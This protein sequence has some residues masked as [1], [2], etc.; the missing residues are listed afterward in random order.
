VADDN[1]QALLLAA[2]LRLSPGTKRTPVIGR[3]LAGQCGR[4]SECD[5]AGECALAGERGLASECGRRA[6]GGWGTERSRVERREHD[7]QDDRSTTGPAPP[8]QYRPEVPAAKSMPL[9]LMPA[10]ERSPDVVFTSLR[11]RRECVWV[12]H[13]HIVGPV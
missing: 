9:E 5:L 8:E 1:Q 13:E 12:S 2:K 11:K 4:P 3:D 6:D 7:P 10:R